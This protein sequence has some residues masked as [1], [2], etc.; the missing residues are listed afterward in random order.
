MAGNHA[1]LS[2]LYETVE[3]GSKQEKL[4]KCVGEVRTVF[5]ASQAME[6]EGHS[7]PK[8]WNHLA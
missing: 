4:K 5:T 6:A 3:F 8:S 2:F 7:L 1:V